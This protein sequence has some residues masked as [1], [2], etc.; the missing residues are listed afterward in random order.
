M[1]ENNNHGYTTLI[2]AR[3]KTLDN[4]CSK[5]DKR[6][7]DEVL[8]TYKKRVLRALNSAELFVHWLTH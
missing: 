8:I 7:R 6:N 1:E 2:I 3:R 5:Y 4:I